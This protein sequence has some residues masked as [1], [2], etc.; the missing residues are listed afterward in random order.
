MENKIR[1]VGLVTCEIFFREVAYFVARSPEVFDITFI[2]KGLH[3]LGGKKMREVIQAEIDKMNE[4]DYRRIVLGYALCNNGI[5]DLTSSRLPLVIPRAHDCITL[6]LGS[7][8]IYREYFF[9]NTGTY[10]HS[11]DWLERGGSATEE[12]YFD[13]Q[14]GPT[15]NKEEFIAN[16]GE[17][18]G[19]YLWSVLNPEKNY[20]KIAYITLPLSGMPDYRNLS[21]KIAKDKGWEWEEIIGETGLL[22][23]LL[24]GPYSEEEFL[25]LK[26]GERVKATND[27]QIIA[28]LP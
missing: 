20:H 2:P 28:S 8:K 14:L 24:N 13:S 21:R 5:I 23:R 15:Q 10:F 22:E 6:F 16:Y 4:K 9:Q 7:R 25:V 27:D 17:E 18:N 3:D 26:P 1:R 19:E 12:Q 11:P